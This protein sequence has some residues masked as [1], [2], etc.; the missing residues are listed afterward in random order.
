ME[1]FNPPP[2]FLASLDAPADRFATDA[3]SFFGSG[4]VEQP[5]GLSTSL[6]NDLGS[7]GSASALLLER[8]I[9]LTPQQNR[10]L[11]FLYGYVP[12]GFNAD[13]LVA[14]YKGDPQHIWSRSSA[15]WKKEGIQFSVPAEP[16]V[17]REASWHNYYLRSSLT[18]DSFFREHIISQGHVYQYIFGFQGAARDPLQHTLPFIF[19]NPEIVRGV[20]RYTLKEI[21]PDGSIPYAIVGSGVPM[22]SAFLPSDQEMWLLWATAEYILATRDKKFLDEKITPYPHREASPSDSTVRELLSRAFSHLIDEIGVGKHGVMRLA[23]GD[24]NDGVVVGRV[25]AEYVEEVHAQ[26]ESVLNAAMAGYVLDYY[27]RMLD[28]VGDT[29]NAGLAHAKAE[30]QRKAVQENWAGKWFKRAWLGP[31]LGWIGEDRIWLEPQPWA[32]IGRA[33]NEEQTKTL[34]A[35]INELLRHPSPIGAML[36]NKGEDTP[37]KRP[38]I[39]ENGGIWPSIN[40]TLIWA[41]AIAGGPAW[42]E[43]KKN[44]LAMH[45]EAYPDIWYGIWS[46]PDTYNSVLSK[47]PGQT[48]FGEPPVDGKKSPTDWGVNWT[49]FPVMNMHSHAWPLYS[50]AKLLGIDFHETG[51]RFNPAIP[52]NEYEFSSPLL[53]FKKTKQGY[54]GW[55]APAVAGRWSV[56]LKLASA[57]AKRMRG[58]NISGESGSL[59]VSD[60]TIRF[61]GES[62]P[63]KPLKWE[64]S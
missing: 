23:K 64:V 17:E 11:C 40:G 44:S 51:V 7:I 37:S 27:A 6:S 55:Y 31:N 9:T 45:A 36:L 15:A 58:V 59:S 38:G 2:T 21:Q 30:G 25:P 18:Y 13:E 43:W 54:S 49:D 57:E 20:I 4:G 50:T 19:S 48:Q 60:Q 10:T 47:Y 16:W 61:S 24:W 34:V 62:T 41:L 42:D 5:S 26:G 29:T 1:D 63:G 3:S 14:K 56:E 8:R 46:G 52:H 53:G 39:L 12:A 33:A 32:M 35:S 22:P 28:Y